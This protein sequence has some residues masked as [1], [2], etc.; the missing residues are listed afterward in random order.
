MTDKFQTYEKAKKQARHI[1]G[2]QKLLHWVHRKKSDMWTNAQ[3]QLQKML[4][5]TDPKKP[6]NPVSMC[7]G[8]KKLKQVWQAQWR[9]LGKEEGMEVS[10]YVGNPGMSLNAPMQQ[11]AVERVQMHGANP[12]MV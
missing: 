12:S 4:R 9:A 1:V 5:P 10:L 7:E 8:Q 2:I 3:G 6:T 11:E